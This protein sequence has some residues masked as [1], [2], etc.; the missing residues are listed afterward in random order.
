MRGSGSGWSGEERRS[1]ESLSVFDLDGTLIRG[2]SSFIFCFY[3]IKKKVLPYS[4]LL[5]ACWNYLCYMYGGRT[6]VQLHQKIFSKILKG[7][8]LATLEDQVPLFIDHMFPPLCYPPALESLR[9]AQHL[10]H[11]TLILSNAPSFLVGPIARYFGVDDYRATEYGV[12]QTFCL[13][14]I[15][16]I[17]QGEDKAGYVLLLAKALGIHPSRVTA[18]SDSHL[19]LPLL[20]IA[21]EAIGVAPDRVLRK[22][23]EKSRWGII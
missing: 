13:S 20:E 3:L 16:S 4:S 5:C 2:N 19:D 10:G 17:M 12:D 14:E 6:L 22:V 1:M 7:L 8:P 15:S 23:C 18:Y 21:G 11:Y 9:R